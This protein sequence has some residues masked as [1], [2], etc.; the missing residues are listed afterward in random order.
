MD[1]SG[2]KNIR[3]KEVSVLMALPINTG[4]LVL[5]IMHLLNEG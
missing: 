5:D 1:M 3:E 2:M 4:L